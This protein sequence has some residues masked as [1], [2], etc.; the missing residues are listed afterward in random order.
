MSDWVRPIAR[1]SPTWRAPRMPM[2]STRLPLE[3][4]DSVLYLGNTVDGQ[5][6]GDLTRDRGRDRDLEIGGTEDGSSDGGG[7]RRQYASGGQHRAQAGRGDEAAPRVLDLT[8][9]PSA[10]TPRSRCRPRSPRTGGHRP[11]S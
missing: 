2:S 3:R 1:T 8:T 11:D 5:C 10:R 9:G 6:H 7:G 4:L